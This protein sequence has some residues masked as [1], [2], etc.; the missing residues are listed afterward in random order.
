MLPKLENLNSTIGCDRRGSRGYR[1]VAAIGTLS[2]NGTGITDAG[3]ANLQAADRC[4][5]QARLT[6]VTAT[7]LRRFE[8]AVPEVKV[9]YDH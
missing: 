6:P 2:L 7:A 5:R 9:E 3:L 4:A 1:E 8:S